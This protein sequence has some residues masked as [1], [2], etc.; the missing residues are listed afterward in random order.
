MRRNFMKFDQLSAEHGKYRFWV[1]CLS[2]AGALA[3]FISIVAS[4]I[5]KIKNY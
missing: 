5:A 2:I 3:S 4:Q 1:A